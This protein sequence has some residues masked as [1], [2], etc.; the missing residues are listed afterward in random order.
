MSHMKIRTKWIGAGLLSS[1][2]CIAAIAHA[3]YEKA[4]GP[5]TVQ[6]KTKAIKGMVKIN[7]SVPGLTVAQQEG[8]NLVFKA[9]LHKISTGIGARD[10]HAKEALNVSKHPMAKLVVPVSSVEEPKGGAI[11]NKP[12]SG[13]FTLN[14]VTKKLKFLY[15]VEEKGGKYIITGKFQIKL[16]D[17][18]VKPP[19]KAGVCVEDKVQVVAKFAMKK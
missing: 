13:D 7:G 12:G 15:D 10:E 14:G 17:Y 1:A 5:N 19:C 4:P 2:L 11:K 16:T 18:G 6:F 3:G 9:E 8:S